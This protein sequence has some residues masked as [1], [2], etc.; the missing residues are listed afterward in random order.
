MRAGATA[1][2][3]LLVA[4]CAA[5]APAPKPVRHGLPLL[6]PSTLGSERS[7]QQ[8]LQAKFG[9]QKATLNAVLQVNRTQLQVIALNAVGMRVFTLVYDG[10]HLRA[11][12]LPG[13]PEQIEPE[14]VLADL[15]LALWPLP[16][17]R[18][19]ALGSAWE[20][21][22]EA[23]LRTLKFKGELV[24]EVRYDGAPWQGKLELVNHEFKYSLAVASRPFEQ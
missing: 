4:A 5:D 10:V 18:A 13:L 16:A 14:R 11:E 17:L 1:V 7:V 8:V 3:A 15:Q 19:V 23:G 2:I 12:T 9:D 6:A 21:A 22:E 20:I 24:A